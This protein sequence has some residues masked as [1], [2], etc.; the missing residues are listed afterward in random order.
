MVDDRT[1]DTLYDAVRKLPRED[2]DACLSFLVINGFLGLEDDIHYRACDALYRPEGVLRQFG[3]KWRR[4]LG[5]KIRE[6]ETKAFSRVLQRFCDDA[7]VRYSVSRAVCDLE[8]CAEKVDVSPDGMS[9]RLVFKGSVEQAMLLADVA[10]NVRRYLEWGE[11]HVQYDVKVRRHRVHAIFNSDNSMDVSLKVD[12]VSPRG[13][14][15][16]YSNTYHIGFDGSGS[17]SVAQ[18]DRY[19]SIGRRLKCQG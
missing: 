17:V 15:A 5:K 18:R 6:R 7:I 3:A 11:Y 16:T 12:A 8:Q 4:R 9:C 1:L 10:S 19:D 14:R 13:Y 2:R